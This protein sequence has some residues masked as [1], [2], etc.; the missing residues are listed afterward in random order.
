M[1]SIFKATLDAEEFMRKAID[2]KGLRNIN[3]DSLYEIDNNGEIIFKAQCVSLSLAKYDKP[4]LPKF[5]DKNKN[6]DIRIS[7]GQLDNLIG[8]PTECNSL[9]IYRTKLQSLVGVPKL[10][11]SIY[12]NSLKGIKELKGIEEMKFKM[13]TVPEDQLTLNRDR[14]FLVY[15]TKLES[16]KYLPDFS[17]ITMNKFQIDDCGLGGEITLDFNSERYIIDHNKFTKLYVKGKPAAV[18][19][20]HNQIT[21]FQLKSID[22]LISLSLNDNQISDIKDILCLIKKKDFGVLKIRKNK[23]SDEDIKKIYTVKES[24][25]NHIYLEV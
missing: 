2:T 20:D 13:C 11:T 4:Y 18:Y 23:I 5:S 19:A 12:F 17:K 6:V 7:D 25:K 22:N 3:D 9:C 10:I 14:E 8:L 21:E 16:L 1:G 24:I 15:N